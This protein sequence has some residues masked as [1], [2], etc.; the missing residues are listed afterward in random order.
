M[1][2]CRECERRVGP[3]GVFLYLTPDG[4]V[5]LCGRLA[6]TRAYNGHGASNG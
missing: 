3:K 4:E 5:W 6:C 2:R 1:K